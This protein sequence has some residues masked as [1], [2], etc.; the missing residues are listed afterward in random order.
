[1]LDD[2]LLVK[3][4]Y[5][6]NTKRSYVI[7]TYVHRS[8]WYVYIAM[9]GLHKTYL[10]WV[11]SVRCLTITN[12]HQCSVVCVWGVFK[13]RFTDYGHIF[14]I[15]MRVVV[16]VRIKKYTTLRIILLNWIKETVLIE[17][18]FVQGIIEY[19]LLAIGT[20]TLQEKIGIVIN[21]IV[22][23]TNRRGISCPA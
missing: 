13:Q 23:R 6:K 4:K 22:N 5:Q 16:A 3:V 12:H 2:K 18:R 15:R 19:Q 8:V 21:M 1:M 20:V 14:V 10:Y 11:W 17:V 9:V 7:H